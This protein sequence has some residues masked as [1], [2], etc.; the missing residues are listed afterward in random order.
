SGIQVSRNN[1]PIPGQDPDDHGDMH[2]GLWMAFSDLG[3]H[4]F[5]RNK[6]PRVEQEKLTI[7]GDGMFEVVNKYVDGDKLI[8]R[9]TNHFLFTPRPQGY[10]ITWDTLLDAQSDNVSLGSDEEMGL[11]VRVATP[12]TVKRGKGHIT[13]S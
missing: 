12:I 9:E 5:W 3:G 13:S 1:P 10:L 6:G 7:L 8:A 2:P 4:D 11:G